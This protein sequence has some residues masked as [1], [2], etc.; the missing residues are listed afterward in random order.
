MSVLHSGLIIMAVF[1]PSSVANLA[2]CC[3]TGTV[4]LNPVPLHRVGAVVDHLVIPNLAA[5]H[6]LILKHV[7]DLCLAHLAV[8]VASIK[9]VQDIHIR[10]HVLGLD[11][12]LEIVDVVIV[13]TLE[14]QVQ[15]A[16]DM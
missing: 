6:L 11:H 15:D 9:A 14:D 2:I 1:S 13:V 7:Q 10:D 5:D 4:I 8:M 3:R 16:V 12:I